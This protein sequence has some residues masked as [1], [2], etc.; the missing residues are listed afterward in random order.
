MKKYL[1]PDVDLELENFNEFYEEQNTL[2]DYIKPDSVI[3]LDEINKYTIIIEDKSSTAFK[4]EEA[5]IKRDLAVRE[6]EDTRPQT[7]ELKNLL[8][9]FTDLVERTEDTL[10]HIQE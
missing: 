7:D 1:I 8:V 6:L 4:R 3:M 9:Q 10:C 2:I 5:K